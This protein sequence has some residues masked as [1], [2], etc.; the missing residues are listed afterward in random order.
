MHE[1]E[2]D[3]IFTY[4]AVL[5]RRKWLILGGTASLIVVVIVAMLAVPK[6]FEATALLAATH[7]K[8][9]APDGASAL[10]PDAVTGLVKNPARLAEAVRRLDLDK[11]PLG[12]TTKQLAESTTV[13]G[14]K[15]TNLLSLSVTLPDGKLAADT[16]N[17]LAE[18]ALELSVHVREGDDSVRQAIAQELESARGALEQADSALL[19]FRRTTRV[20]LLQAE[21]RARVEEQK[22]LRQQLTAI[23]VEQAGIRA[24]LAQL[25]TA[26]QRHEPLITLRRS[27]VD[28]PTLPSPRAPQAP[29]QK[30]AS[31]RPLQ[32]QEINRVH[33]ELQQRIVAGEARAAVLESQRTAMDR[34][35]QEN[36]RRLR[37]LAPRVATGEAK[38]D[39]L[40]RSRASA[41][42]MYQTLVRKLSE[43]VLAG[44]SRATKLELVDRANPPPIPVARGLRFSA[45]IAALIGIVG[46]ALAALVLEGVQRA[47]ASRPARVEAATR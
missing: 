1:T 36:D 28:D 9:G 30:S 47:R 25:K 6:R 38:L 31:D 24:E 7:A 19:D 11:P 23:G 42:A 2:E 20:D 10:G 3:D 37:E 26:L 15:G 12:L 39:Q 8:A 18:R 29:E 40:T 45:L 13:K 21:E 5:W 22:R 14:I 35:I 46:F 34:Q 33:Q 4:L 41:E 44:A 27:L 32:T 17:F 43:A 16:A